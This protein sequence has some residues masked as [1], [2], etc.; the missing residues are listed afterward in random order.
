MMLLLSACAS[1]RCG[2]GTLEVAGVCRGAVDAAGDSQPVPGGGSGGSGDTGD[3]SGETPMIDVYIL[4]GQSNMDGY[5][6]YPGLAPSEQLSDP[7]VPLY[8]SGWAEFRDLTAASYGGALYFGP[9]VTFGR[10][11]ADHGHAI[12]LVKHAVGGTDL[13]YYWYPGATP[14]D[15]DAGEGFATL[16]T[17]LDGA[18][19]ALDAAGQPWHYAGFLWMQGESDSM[20]AGMASLYEVNLT[21]LIAS[22]RTITG[23]PELPAVIGLISRESIWTYADVVREAEQ[24]VA[25][26][27]PTIV[28]VETDDLPRST[29]DQPHY[30]GVSMRVLGRRFARAVEELTDV[31]AGSD[32]PQAAFTVTTGSL[33]YD[34]T[35]TCGWEFTTTAP[36]E[37]TDVGGYGSTYLW[38][39]ADVGIWDEAGNLLLRTT[40]PSWYEAPA[41]WRGSVWYVAVEPLALEPGTYRI[42][43]V[44]WTE[45]SDRYLD[46]ALGSFAGPIDYT[47]GVYAEG[48]W[49]TYPANSVASE[50]MNF[51]GPDFLF[52]E[53]G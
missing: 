15:Q 9:E 53:G 13:A 44:S 24:H 18:S 32:A 49:L 29:L 19:A 33:D 16:V 28:A 43:L 23:E 39:S 20:D 47:A 14:G 6:W 3:S 25:D 42:G 26:A 46:N 38:T 34:F 30:D 2:E 51:L 10:T 35:G 22:V 12:A 48:N 7:R 40:I 41:N 36:I 4:A 52:V 1:L 17:T 8:W 50:A 45:D 21:R 31:P 37:I 27:D 5:A 11:M